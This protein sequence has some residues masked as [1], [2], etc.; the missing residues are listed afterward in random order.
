MDVNVFVVVSVCLDVKGRE[1]L[2][3]WVLAI[4]F[5]EKDAKNYEESRSHHMEGSR[6]LSFDSFNK[7]VEWI[8]NNGYGLRTDDKV[9]MRC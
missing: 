9:P 4:F 8:N 1:E 6:I 3:E 2:C 7:A 5:D